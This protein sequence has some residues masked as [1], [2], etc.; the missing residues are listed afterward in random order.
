M[1]G[2]GAFFSNVSIPA[3][4]AKVVIH[5]INSILGDSIVVWRCYHVYGQSWRICVIP[6]LLILASAICGFGQGAT[7]ALARTTHSAFGPNLERWNGSLFILS[8]VTNVTVTS[9]IA[10]RVW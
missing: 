2:P 6:C 1:T 3:N 8:L 5:T 9:L 7:F 4:V 10:F